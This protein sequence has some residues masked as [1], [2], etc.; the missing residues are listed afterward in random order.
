MADVN[1]STLCL[2]CKAIFK[3]APNSSL[4]GHGHDVPHHNLENLSARAVRGCHLCLTVYMS[5]DPEALT[6]FRKLHTN[7]QGLASITPI[8][9]DQA[10]LVFKYVP[11]DVGN[12][13][14]F[15]S[16]ATAS[17]DSKPEN[18]LTVELILLKPECTLRATLTPEVPTNEPQMPSSPAS[19][20]STRKPSAP[21]PTNLLKPPNAG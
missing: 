4:I 14:S 8:A 19:R 7:S 11:E 17:S 21:A 2:A 1:L 10:R 5:L 13:Q 18:V 3:S 9:R 12:T 20:P 6:K 16:E 15:Y